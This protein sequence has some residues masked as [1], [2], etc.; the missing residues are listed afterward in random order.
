MIARLDVGG[1]DS[2]RPWKKHLLPIV[3]VFVAGLILSCVPLRDPRFASPPPPTREPIPATVPVA[4]AAEGYS[5]AA[6]KAR[7]WKQEACLADVLALYDWTGTEWK[8]TEFGY[9]FIDPPS[10]GLMTIRIKPEARIMEVF[11][12]VSLSANRRVPNRCLVTRPDQWQEKEALASVTEML[13]AELASPCGEVRASVETFE[14]A[15]SFSWSIRI[16]VG[17]AMRPLLGDLLLDVPSGE[18]HV[19][20]KGDP[21]TPCE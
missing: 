5:L 15:Q 21:D 17:I 2:H 18:I 3:I 14:A 12:P 6:E 19:I 9:H 8:A 16:G 10:E 20:E 4:Y 11:R 7:A 13:R 1:G